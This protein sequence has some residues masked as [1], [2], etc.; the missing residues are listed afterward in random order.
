MAVKPKILIVESD[1]MLRNMLEANLRAMGAEPRCVSTALEATLRIEHDKFDG[2]FL[3]WSSSARGEELTRRIR[4]SKSNAKIPIA[5]LASQK[6]THAVKTGFALGVTFHL[7]KP[8]GQK[9]LQRLLNATRGTML[10]ERRRYMRIPVSV[11]VICEWFEK[12][13]AKRVP[14][15]SV[16]LSTTGLLV[17]L[18]PHPTLGIEASLDMLLPALKRNLTPRGLV[19]RI[20][21]EHHVAF[22][23]VKFPGE[24]RELLETF[25]TREPTGTPELGSSL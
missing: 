9:E 13:T 2:V 6:D 20:T 8:F 10:E 18:T 4:T 21:P 1:S 7:A 22:Q 19:K 12:E 17:M 24:E 23:F 11:P 3:D 25:L 5:M 14:G 15:K 16:N